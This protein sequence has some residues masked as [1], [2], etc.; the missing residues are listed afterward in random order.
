MGLM[1]AAA[2]VGIEAYHGSVKRLLSNEH[3]LGDD[4]YPAIIDEVTF[5]KAQEEITRRAEALGRNGRKTKPREIKPFRRFR[6]G[7]LTEHFDSPV[8]QA[9]YIYS[10][11]ESEVS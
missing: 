7:E 11:I 9:E 1:S 3:Y 2:E 5:D 8:Q 6:L 10:Q 4:F